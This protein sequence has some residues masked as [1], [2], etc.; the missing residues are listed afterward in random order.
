MHLV[1]QK[2]QTVHIDKDATQIKAN[3]TIR[4]EV[5]YKYTFEGFAEMAQRAGFEVRQVWTDPHELFSVQ[6]LVAK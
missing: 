5:S 4:T 2:D 6:F 1:S 3:E